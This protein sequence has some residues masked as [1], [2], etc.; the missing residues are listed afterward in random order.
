[1]PAGRY[2]LY[3]EARRLAAEGGD[4]PTA[5]QAVEELGQTFALSP[6][7]VFALKASALFSASK[8]NIASESYQPVVDSALML[9]DAAVAADD[10]EAPLGLLTTADAA[11]RKLKAIPLIR[12]LEKRAQE[13]KTLQTAYAKVKPFADT[14]RRDPA[15][16]KANFVV[17]RYQAFT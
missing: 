5:L 15:D 1:F 3:Q 4:I 9:L 11:A 10:Y 12:S 8:A 13:I 6:E 16:A 7:E 2:A 14:L 17:G